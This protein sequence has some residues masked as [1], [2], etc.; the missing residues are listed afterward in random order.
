MTDQSVDHPELESAAG[1]KVQ[2]L[3]AEHTALRAEVLQRDTGLN[4]FIMVG[5]L[6]FVAIIALVVAF[7]VLLLGAALLLIL[8]LS[9]YLVF[10]FIEH[11]VLM[12]ATRLSEIENEINARMGEQLMK[13]EA[14]CGLRRV[15]YGDR[16]RHT[17]GI[18][19][20]Q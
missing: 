1:S 12:C 15:G 8:A 13:W 14:T 5:S 20:R 7:H 2:I 9:Q 19:R 4:Q 10:K 16:L 18:R 17:F 11:D 6:E 3:L